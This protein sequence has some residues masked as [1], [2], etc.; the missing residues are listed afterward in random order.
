[1]SIF[2]LK[3]EMVSSLEVVVEGVVK[4]A[5]K[6]CSEKYDFDYLE[7]L[8]L[9]NMS[10][11]RVVKESVVKE[12]MVKESVV[13]E[14]HMHMPFCGIKND[15][16]CSGLKEN[17]GLYT[18]CKNPRKDDVKFC[19]V[20]KNQA[21][22]NGGV[23]KYGTIE[24]RCAVDIMEFQDPRGKCPTAYTKI[25][26]KFNYTKEGVLEEA[27]RQNITIDERH[28]E[29]VSVGKRGRP[30]SV[31]KEEKAKGTKGRPKKEKKVME[32][33]GS[34]DLFEELVKAGET[35]VEAEK[36]AEKE[37]E[38]EEEKEDETPDVVKRITYEGKKYLRSK[39]TGIIYNEEQDVVGKWVES[40]KSIEFF[41][42]EEEEEEY[43]E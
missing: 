6:V 40:T 28:F 38:V 17:W 23:P 27:N 24:D 10:S 9:L 3:E 41:E 32:V 34:G 5:I 20:C 1:M 11:F 33:S 19:K 7:A 43:E 12:S 26:E 2:N 31:N 21:D 18:Q 36:E 13:K 42:E 29:A 37:V 4:N 16:C 35:E 8:S 22:K 15:M 30:K 25:M 39:K 14:V